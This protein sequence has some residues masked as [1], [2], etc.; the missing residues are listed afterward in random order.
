M[1]RA[2]AMAKTKE[3][4]GGSNLPSLNLFQLQLF[5][6]LAALCGLVLPQVVSCRS[7]WSS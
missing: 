4:A 3:M 7:H 2:A 5:I 1:D 6:P